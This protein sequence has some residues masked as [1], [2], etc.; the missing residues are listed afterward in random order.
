MR[1]SESLREVF[2]RALGY[3]PTSLNGVKFRCDPY[4]VSFWR[5]VSRGRWKPDTYKVLSKFL[6]PDSVYYDIGAWIGP[7][8][9]FAASRCKQV[10]CFEP[11]P[12]AFQYLLWNISLNALRNVL[13]INVAL[14]DRSALMRMASFDKQLG[15]S[16]TSLLKT[17]ST[18]GAT[19]VLALTWKEW[20]DLSEGE[21]PDFLKIDIEGGEF[22]LLPTL[23]EYLSVHR[24]VVYLSTHAPFL[25]ANE[26][27]EQ[28][29]KV[30][31]VME[32][33][34]S[35]LKENLEPVAVTELVGEDALE[36]FRSYVFLDR[37]ALS[38]SRPRG[39]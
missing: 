28:M 33:Y 20:L 2:F 27:R 31:E 9:L 30:I 24:P 29:R 3:Y 32:V 5:K 1:V 19:D 34:D 8:A 26:R 7:T 14:A 39:L 12:V 37:S 38:G 23:K 25:K 11:D 22:A 4:H 36:H 21:P 13:P 35:C 16:M 15:D 10:V 6:T 17:C 18:E